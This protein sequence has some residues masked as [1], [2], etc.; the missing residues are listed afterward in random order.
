MA[1]YKIVVTQIM[2]EVREV[3]ADSMAELQEKLEDQGEFIGRCVEPTQTKEL[4]GIIYTEDG[5]RID[6]TL[7]Y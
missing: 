3:E 5:I 4:S 2:Q 7:F 6:K 1:K